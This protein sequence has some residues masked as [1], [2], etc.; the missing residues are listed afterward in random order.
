MSEQYDS[1]EES[2]PMSSINW[3]LDFF[4]DAGIPPNSAAEYAVAF[5]EQRIPQDYEIILELGKEEWQE[6]GVTVLGDRLAMKN[7]AKT[8][9]KAK[10]TPKKHKKI[11]KTAQ[12]ESTKSSEHFLSSFIS[13]EKQRAK[14]L[15]R[16]NVEKERVKSKNPFRKSSQEHEE[17]DD[18]DDHETSSMPSSA[19]TY[20]EEQEEPVQ[21]VRFQV[22]LDKNF[23]T[24]S[25]KRQSDSDNNQSSSSLPKITRTI[26]AV[27]EDIVSSSSKVNI[28]FNGKCWLDS[29]GA[30]KDQNISCSSFKPN[31]NDSGKKSKKTEVRARLGKK[32]VKNRLGL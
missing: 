8:D 23:G 3:W 7:L 14:P 18:F 12:E 2:N 15:G 32:N 20:S 19:I 13:K 24:S 28:T 25:R 29:F 10:K 26:G 27:Q 11:K 6:L 9:G 1:G 17:P 31:T 16:Q 30:K 5:A 21:E 4:A 22:N